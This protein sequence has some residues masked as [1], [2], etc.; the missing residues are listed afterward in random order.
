M[1]T[2]IIIESKVTQAPS[3]SSIILALSIHSVIE[4]GNRCTGSNEAIK[5]YQHSGTSQSVKGEIIYPEKRANLS[6][7]AIKVA[8]FSE[9]V[10]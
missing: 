1:L 2:N 7:T 5:L 6:G 4:I 9:K 10:H 8:K 3:S